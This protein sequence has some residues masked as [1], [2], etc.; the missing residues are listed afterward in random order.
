MARVPAWSL[1]SGVSLYFLLSP[2]MWLENSTFT[3]EPVFHSHLLEEQ[4]VLP[5]EDVLSTL[6]ITVMTSGFSFLWENRVPILYLMC[7]YP[8][9]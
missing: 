1:H 5:A 3:L 7:S 2:D 8:L 9:Q 6:R 4:G